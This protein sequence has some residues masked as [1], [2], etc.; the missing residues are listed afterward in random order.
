MV[1][2]IRFQAPPEHSFEAS[3]APSI[4]PLPERLKSMAR[5]YFWSRPNIWFLEPPESRFEAF[6]VPGPKLLPELFKNMAREL[7]LSLDRISGFWNLQKAGLKHFWFLAQ[8]Y[9]QNGS[10]I[11]RARYFW[12]WTEYV[13]FATSRKPF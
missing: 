10:K 3:L 1:I 11:W 13:V 12:V 4:K 5:A 7:F 8:N 2:M 9:C 6:V